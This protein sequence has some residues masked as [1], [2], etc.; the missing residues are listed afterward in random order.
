LAIDLGGGNSQYLKE[1]LKRITGIIIENCRPE[2]IILFGSLA[3]GRAQ[4]HSDLDLLVLSLPTAK[5][6][7]F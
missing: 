6:G 2:K 1:E 4:E 3:G 5:A 7:G